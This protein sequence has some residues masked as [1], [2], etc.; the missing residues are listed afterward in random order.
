MQYAGSSYPVNHTMIQIYNSLT[1][2]NYKNTTKMILFTRFYDH[3]PVLYNN[4]LGFYIK[5]TDVST[6]T[7]QFNLLY[8][9]G[10]VWPIYYFG[11]IVYFNP[12]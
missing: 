8:P 12:D 7:F 1:W 6:S 4:S 2:T 9:F 10:M 3:N 5:F 11:Y